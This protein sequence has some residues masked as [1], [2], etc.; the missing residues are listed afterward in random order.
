MYQ[1]SNESN[2]LNNKKDHTRI[3]EWLIIVLF[4]RQFL[5]YRLSLLFFG[6]LFTNSNID[7]FLN[8]G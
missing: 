3:W 5:L 6:V 1:L 7:Y 4:A 8:K 2:L